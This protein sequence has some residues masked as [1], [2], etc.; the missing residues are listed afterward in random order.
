M[1][2]KAILCV[3][4]EKMILESLREQFSE[5]NSEDFAYEFAESAEEGMALIKSLVE[6]GFTIFTVVADWLM[7]GM[8]GDEFLYWV[9]DNYPGCNKILLTGHVD[10]EVVKA[11][12]C[13]D[14]K[15]IHCV[16]KPW[17]KDNL[18]KLVFGE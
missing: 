15:D 1:S 13:C 6:E 2:G 12:A 8:K 9:A 16:Y 10:N 18:N 17:N 14:T 7:P 11:L 5:R 3:D 4:D